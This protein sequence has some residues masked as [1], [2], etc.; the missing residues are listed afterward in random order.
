MKNTE[1]KSVFDSKFSL[2]TNFNQTNNTN[3]SWQ[4]VLERAQNALYCKEIY[5]Q[6]YLF[7]FLEK[8]QFKL[9]SKNQLLR[10][11][12]DPNN[13]QELRPIITGNSIKMMVKKVLLKFYL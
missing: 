1:P 3:P 9:H 10:E 8:F 11:V 6:V 5:H 4:D 13:T 12:F 2:F 7:I